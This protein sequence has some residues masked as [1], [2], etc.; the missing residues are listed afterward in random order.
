M[1]DAALRNASF[2]SS[3]IL[4]CIHRMEYDVQSSIMNGMGHSMKDLHIFLDDAFSYIMLYTHPIWTLSVPMPEKKRYS[5]ATHPS[6]HAPDVPK[7]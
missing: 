3:T 1:I 7:T 6:G 4:Y 2:V 5:T